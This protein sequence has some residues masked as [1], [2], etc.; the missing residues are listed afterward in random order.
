MTGVP[1]DPSMFDY[2]ARPVTPRIVLVGM[3]ASPVGYAITCAPP[4]ARLVVPGL[5]I[6]WMP[7]R[8][9]TR[10]LAAHIAIRPLEDTDDE[11]ARPRSGH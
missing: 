3:R 5:W 11:R 4:V 2:D 8:T 1:S 6:P 10:T 9:K 7:S